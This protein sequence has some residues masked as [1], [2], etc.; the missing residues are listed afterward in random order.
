MS[1]IP[2]S[3]WTWIDA[4]A[5]RFERACSDESRPRIEDYLAAVD[6]ER[7]ARLLDELL[8]V[9]TELRR[10]AGEQPTAEEYRRRFEHYGSV[11]D[12]VFAQ[13]P[14]LALR[15]DPSTTATGFEA[16][17]AHS[18]HEP[19]GHVRYFGDYELIR[20]LGRGGMGVVYEAQ[21]ITLKR[22][23]A[24]KMIRSASLASE[25]EQRR[26]Q[27]EAE[28]IALLDH[29][30]IV[31]ILEVGNHGGQRFFSMKL[32]GGES[33]DKKLAFYA[34][35]PKAAAR[36]LKT[37]AEAVHH[38]HQRGVLHRDLKPANIL[39]D[40]RGEPHVTDFGL[41]KR[42]A[43][44][45]ELTQSGAIMGTPAYMAPEQ[46]SGRRG[47]VTTSSDIYGLGAVLYALLTG[48]A[49]F[50]GDSVEET[51]EQVR[52]ALPP[53]PSKINSLVARDLEVICLKCME[54][55][56]AERYATAG[57]LADDLDRFA[58]G[59]PVSARA[60]GLVERATKWAR[61][62][63]TLAAAYT[64]AFLA[65]GLG[66]L[67]DAAVWQWRSAERARNVAELAQ[68]EAERQREL[69][70][71]ARSD[72]EAARELEVKARADADLQ[73]E[74]FERFEYGR[75]IQ[76]AH[77]DWR[78][79]DVAAAV[80]LLDN[81]RDRFR[82]WEWRYVHRLCHSDQLTL[83][84]HTGAVFSASFSPDG[85]RVVTGSEDKTAK[86]WNA[87]S[88]AVVLI[89]KGHAG[90]I[91]SAS[92][93][94]DGTR[95]V[96]ASEDK[97]AKIWNVTSG[98]EVLALKGHNGAVSSASFS[99]SGTR[100]SSRRVKTKRLR[101]GMQ[102]VAPRSSHSRATT[103]PYLRH[104]SALTGSASSRRVK[105]KRRRSGMQRVAPKSSRSKYTLT[106]RRSA[107]TGR[108]S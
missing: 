72:A 78:E 27:N 60:A 69:A 1:E 3:D 71:V 65:L 92:F 61:R 68:V 107:R 18:P 33:L 26:F 54:K 9:E 2:S 83:K 81:T 85:T 74:R 90:I 24:L 42:V 6:E 106:L 102:R 80:A 36:L 45:S 73:R 21:Q 108:A 12:A 103:A 52:S 50:G 16:D 58:A 8:R 11:V 14:V 95:V 64:L 20:E 76:V 97:T 43:G 59:D 63:P 38:A 49:P 89:L 104:R 99:P 101:S 19:V 13:A 77:Q 55:D 37:A 79:A 7:R 10:R 15:T 34:G 30:H 57:A 22:L 87:M 98:A 31:P 39:L 62:K 84:G 66:G 93:S 40:D 75:T 82:G 96:T 94:P 29:P 5:N 17:D 51:L 4:A 46:A 48:R 28:A 53:P 23:V 105:T 70:D 35:E 41:A 91:R 47:A 44:D 67:G 56:P 86:I 88:G 25:D 32:I 100:S